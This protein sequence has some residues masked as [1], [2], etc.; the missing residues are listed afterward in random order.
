MD[1]SKIVTSTIKLINPIMES[2]GMKIQKPTS[3][4]EFL[5]NIVD[6]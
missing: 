3:T 4:K 1:T 5:T 2:L 6:L